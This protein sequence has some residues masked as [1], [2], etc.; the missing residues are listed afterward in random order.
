MGSSVLM[1]GLQSTWDRCTEAYQIGAHGSHTTS[2]LGE[3]AQ[4]IAAVGAAAACVWGGEG[5]KSH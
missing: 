2:F 5:E 1:P 4:Q 3:N